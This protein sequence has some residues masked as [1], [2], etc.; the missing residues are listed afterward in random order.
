MK[1][2]PF[3]AEEIQDAAVVCKHCGRDLK[4]GA[5]QVQIVP[6]K[7]KTGCVAAGCAVII[8]LFVLGGIASMCNPRP[9]TPASAPVPPPTTLTKEQGEAQRRKD[10][11]AGLTETKKVLGDPKLCDQPKAIADA[12]TNLKVTRKDDPEWAEAKGLAP[13]LEACRKKAEQTLS[14]GMQSLMV[15]QREQWAK[16]AEKKM[17]DQGMEVD[18][19]LSGPQKD[20]LSMK[21]V[22]MS[23]VAVHKI[24]ND[25]SMRE[26]AFLANM[27]KVGFKRVHFSDGYN[28]GVY[29]DLDP[30]SEATGG[31]VVLRQMGLGT[32]I[33]LQ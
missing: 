4:G 28:F 31:N 7:K 19:T 17:L 9:K 18:C 15:T 6:P 30:P 16:S 32:P 1:Q 25:G 11:V 8:A 21:W 23:K 20:R 24:T 14:K 3:C 5:S 22:L 29:Y 26:G 27:Q 33:A 12:W 13:R 2:C 10:V